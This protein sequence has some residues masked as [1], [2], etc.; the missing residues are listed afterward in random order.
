[1]IPSSFATCYGRT[2]FDPRS[3]QLMGKHGERFVIARTRNRRLHWEIF[4]WISF[5]FPAQTFVRTRLYFPAQILLFPKTYD[6]ATNP[7]SLERLA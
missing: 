6:L 7:V 4:F 3:T 1:M 2:H 5:K